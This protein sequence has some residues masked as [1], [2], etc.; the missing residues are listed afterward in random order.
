MKKKQILTVLLST[1]LL[2]LSL[3]LFACGGD[4]TTTT[5]TGGGGVPGETYTITFMANGEVVG[6]RT[7]SIG[8]VSVQEP[9]APAF[10]YGYYGEGVS[11]WEP[12]TLDGGD[13]TVHA[14]T[15]RQTQAKYTLVG[16][17]YH[18]TGYNGLADGKLEILGN[19]NGKP[20]T[21][22][23]AQ[24]LQST[25]ALTSV[26]VPSSIVSM[27][28]KAFYSCTSLKEISFEAGSALTSV[29]EN[30]FSSCSALKTVNIGALADWC[31]ISFENANANPL[32][33]AHALTL[34]GTVLTDA[35]I[36]LGVTKIG[37]YA[38]CNNNALTRVTVPSG[39]TEIEKG[40]FLYCRNLTE[41]SL[42][43]GLTKIGESAFMSCGKLTS[44]TLPASVSM[45]DTQAFALC[46][47]L[48]SVTI[49]SDT[50][51]KS[52][53]EKAFYECPAL[54]SF[55]IPASVTAIGKNAFALTPE[56]T[57]P[58]IPVLLRA[59]PLAAEPVL[60][61]TSVLFENPNGWV[62]GDVSLSATDLSDPAKAAEYLRET[63]IAQ[64]WTRT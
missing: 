35:V 37:K 18:V 61:L 9:T 54:H 32:T 15:T 62:C 24:A 43:S 4:D 20:V 13:K 31:K 33:F 40:A 5:T 11:S 3:F 8:D 59:T 45:L 34:N 64:N 60:G 39:V 21:V 14:V 50:Q 17:V 44:L 56:W 63:Y 41:L 57:D 2:L 38:F 51:L 28:T 47:T 6:T 42:P 27:E 7:Y 10:T 12:Y 49:P 53:G 16:D 19:Y 25:S 48:E 58:V 1:V 22:I 26:F 55:V 29:G 36:P 52:I 46:K 30:A 23:G